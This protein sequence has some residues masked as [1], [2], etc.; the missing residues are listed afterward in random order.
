MIGFYGLPI[1]YLDNFIANIKAVDIDEINDAL[2][3]RL[4]PDKMVTV[5]VGKQ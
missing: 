1:D 3:R 5:I 2:S 4:D